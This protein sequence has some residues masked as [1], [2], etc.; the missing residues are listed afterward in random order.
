LEVFI[1]DNPKLKLEKRHEIG[2]GRARR[3]L[4]NG[5]VPA[6][7]YGSGY[8]S[9]AAQVRKSEISRLLRNKGRNTLF[10]TEFAEDQDITVIIKDILYDPVNR[11]IIHLDFQKVDPQETVQIQ[12]PVRVTGQEAGTRAGNSVIHQLNTVTV[13]CPASNIPQFADVDISK[14][15]P[16]QSFTVS[17]LSFGPGVKVL[18]DPGKVVLTIKGHKSEPAPEE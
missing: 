18:T 8:G 3:L 7:V 1:M 10:N 6:V 5:L 11:D 12:V 4:E 17:N 16:G 13:E 9:A 15:K 2:G 14:M